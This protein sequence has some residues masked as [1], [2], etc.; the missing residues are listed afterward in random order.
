MEYSLYFFSI[1]EKMWLIIVCYGV[2]EAISQTDFIE[3]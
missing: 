3:V 1:R 2:E